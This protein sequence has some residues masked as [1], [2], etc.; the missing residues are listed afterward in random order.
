MLENNNEKESDDS[1]PSDAVIG[2]N[3]GDGDKILFALLLD[4]FWSRDVNLSNTGQVVVGLPVAFLGIFIPATIVH[5]TPNIWEF[6]LWLI[7]TLWKCISSV[8]TLIL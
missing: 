3:S 5:Y 2:E 7:F 4:E 8:K 1:F 6:L